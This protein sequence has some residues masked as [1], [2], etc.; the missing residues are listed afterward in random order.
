[1]SKPP[2]PK[3]QTTNWPAYNHALKERGQLLLWLDQDMLWLA[4]ATD[5]R[6]RQPTFSDTAI[7][8][9]LTI[10][11]LF[12]L[13]LR[14]ATGMVES[15]FRLAGLDWAVPD[16]ST[17]S[18]RQK[19]LQVHIPVQ[20]KQ[21]GLHLLVDS[22][23]IKMM[24]E[25][26]RKVKKHGADYRRQWRKLHLGIDAQTLEIRAMEVTDNRTGDATMLP[27]LLSQ[28]PEAEELATVTT[29]G[30]YDT[31]LC[32]AAIAQR[33]AAAIIPPR[34]NGQFWKG[35]SPGNQARNESLRSVKYLGR[36]L[37]KKWS[38]YHRRS[39]VET[40]MHCFKLLVDQ[41][42]SRDFDRQVAELQICA[43]ILNR[44]TA[45]GTPQTVRRG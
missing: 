22:T 29:D 39:L 18:R 16:L 3:Y 24:G 28:I 32:H 33:R 20:K 26:E 8:F 11:C 9:C 27:E 34:Q 1:M 45:L 2:A 44:F 25:G 13:A 12:G 14:Q 17:L 31:H 41:V 19:D 4:S 38:G 43:A 23:G 7:Q 21:G 42:K 15:M 36:T 40:K 10:K 37:W 5:N 6:G 35:D 30:A